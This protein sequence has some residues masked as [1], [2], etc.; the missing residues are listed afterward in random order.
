M[1]VLRKLPRGLCAILVLSLRI[2]FFRTSIHSFK[3]S[4]TDQE[5]WPGYRQRLDFDRLWQLLEFQKE[6]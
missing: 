3:H 1:E 2:L 6:M 5:L 4:E